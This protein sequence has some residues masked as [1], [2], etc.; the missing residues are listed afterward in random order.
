M[1]PEDCSVCGRF[2]LRTPLSVLS[3]QFH[4]QVA[5]HLQLALRYNVAPTQQVAVVRRREDLRE[6]TT[7]RWGLIPSWAKDAKVGFSGINARAD[8]VATKPAFRA[9]YQ[10]RRCLVLAD[11]YYEWKAEGKAKLPQLYEIDGGQPFAFAGLWEVWRGNDSQGE[12][13]ESCTVITTDANEL[14]RAVCDRMP[15]I[16]S[17][18]DYDAW[19]D[20]VNSDVGYMLDSFPPDRMTVRPVSTFVNNARNE[21]AECIAPLA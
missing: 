2:T 5:P 11:G 21:G 17:P 4:A 15:V 14:A 16:L 13:L 7:M 12:P 6:L 19:L 3:T 18:Q 1:T 9:A 10:R 20:P 8:T